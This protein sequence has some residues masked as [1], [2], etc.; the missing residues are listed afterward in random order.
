MVK[1]P[2]RLDRLVLA[3]LGIAHLGA[4][5]LFDQRR[6]VSGGHGL[7][8]KIPLRQTAAHRPEEVTLLGGFNAFQNHIKPDCLPELEQ[9]YFANKKSFLG[10]LKIARNKKKELHCQ[11]IQMSAQFSA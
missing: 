2:S 5:Q 10:R 1:L 11:Y 3:V 7:C 9:G 6:H 4:V 8:I